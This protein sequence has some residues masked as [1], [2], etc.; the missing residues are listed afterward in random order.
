MSW[1]HQLPFTNRMHNCHAGN[2]TARRPQRLEAEPGTS[3]PFHR[4]VAL[5][6]DIIEIF[7]VAD[8]DARLVSLVVPLD[9]CRIRTT[10]V[11][12]DLLGSPWVRGV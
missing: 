4:S 9:C 6:R 11:D 12:G 1:G 5:L 8:N 2:R 3:D 10:V 7:G